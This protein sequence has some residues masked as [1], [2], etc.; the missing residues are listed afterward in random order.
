MVMYLSVMLLIISNQW[1]NGEYFV[2]ESRRFLRIEWPDGPS[3]L[4]RQTD[5]M[6]DETRFTLGRGSEPTTYKSLT[7]RA[8]SFCR[9]V[10]PDSLRT[11]PDCCI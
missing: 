10:A 4:R 7:N 5:D 1:A 3:Y 9:V 2:A 11:L 8:R 6:N